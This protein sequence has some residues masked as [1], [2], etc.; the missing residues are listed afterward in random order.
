MLIKEV[1]RRA[2]LSKVNQLILSFVPVFKPVTTVTRWQCEM[3]GQS[4][5]PC[6]AKTPG[7][8]RM[9]SEDVSSA[10]ALVNK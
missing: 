5:L 9:T 1:V 4:Q 2:N 7:W 8:R 3:S 10:L 6:F